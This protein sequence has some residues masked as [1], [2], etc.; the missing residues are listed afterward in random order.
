MPRWPAW[1][2]VLL[3]MPVFWLA[4]LAC[5]AIAFPVGRLIVTRTAGETVETRG[6]EITGEVVRREV[7]RQGESRPARHY[8]VLRYAPPGGEERLARVRVSH[9]FH[10]AHR[11]GDPVTLRVVPDA[12]RTIDVDGETVRRWL[13]ELPV[14][15]LFL[16]FAGVIVAATLRDLRQMR[17]ALRHGEVIWGRVRKV[18]GRW[19]LRR[20]ELTARPRDAEIDAWG[21]SLWLRPA[22]ARRLAQAQHVPVICGLRPHRTPVFWTGDLPGD[23]PPPDTPPPRLPPY[24]VPPISPSARQEPAP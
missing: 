23:L 5:L 12:P 6:V 20:L 7:V 2:P 11:E 1:I 18:T 24:A 22:T 19:P 21:R 13:Y 4:L 14:I 10:R 8:L 15:A 17:T 3:R 16:F 9:A